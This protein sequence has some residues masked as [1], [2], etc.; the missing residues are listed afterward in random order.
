MALWNLYWVKNSGC[1][2]TKISL[3]SLAYQILI[4]SFNS[5]AGHLLKLKNYLNPDL[6]LLPNS[7][8]LHQ[9]HSVIY[10]EGLR[11]FKHVS[12]LGYEL[13]WN[14]LKFTSNY[15]FILNQSNLD[16]KLKAISEYKSQNFR[17]YKSKEYWKGLAVV[18]GN[19][20]G[21]KFAEA[22]EA[23]RLIN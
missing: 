21:A 22:F 12:I 11:A 23:I 14:N 8:D 16:A 1:S 4:Y 17:T 20:V 7:N 5:V 13:P 6:V 15:H 3:T 9:D 18:R 19:Q 10:Q 2:I